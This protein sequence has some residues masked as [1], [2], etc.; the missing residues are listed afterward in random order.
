MMVRMMAVWVFILHILHE[1][2]QLVERMRHVRELVEVVH[3]IFIRMTL[4][5][6]ITLILIVGLALPARAAIILEWVPFFVDNFDAIFYV[7]IHIF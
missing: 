7:V 3:S 6:V 5:F 1:L 2:L 4:V